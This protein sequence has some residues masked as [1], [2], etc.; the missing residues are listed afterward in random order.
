MQASAR[1]AIR[2]QWTSFAF[3]VFFHRLRSYYP[4]IRGVFPSIFSNYIYYYDHLTRVRYTTVWPTNRLE[5]PTEVNRRMKS[6]IKR[7]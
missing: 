5:R 6:S 7:R 2:L 3:A 4:P 1:D